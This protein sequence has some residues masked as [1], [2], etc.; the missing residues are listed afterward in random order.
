[1]QTLI[2]LVTATKLLW[3]NDV[4]AK[5]NHV[6]AQYSFDNFRDLIDTIGLRN[7]FL[8]IIAYLKNLVGGVDEVF[9]LNQLQNEK[10]YSTQ[11]SLEKVLKVQNRDDWTAWQD[12]E[13]SLMCS[14]NTL[15]E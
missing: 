9:D 15:F 3:K 5:A 4:H 13:G 10:D 7:D 2:V 8:T 12:V 1:M 14:Y 6:S 11:I